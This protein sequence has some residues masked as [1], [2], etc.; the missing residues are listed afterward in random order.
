MD[1][2]KKKVKALQEAGITTDY[3]NELLIL[4]DKER[5]N[6]ADNFYAEALDNLGAN[7]EDEDPV[8]RS[9]HT[10]RTGLLIASH[11]AVK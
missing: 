2:I 4:I 1:L 11:A 7:E 6:V 9:N 5:H 10:I 8:L 3:I